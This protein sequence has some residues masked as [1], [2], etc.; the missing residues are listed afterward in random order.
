MV[1]GAPSLLVLLPALRKAGG[2]AALTKVSRDLGRGRPAVPEAGRQVKAGGCVVGRQWRRVEQPARKAESH[3]E[4]PR[5]DVSLLPG[6]GGY[7]YNSFKPRVYSTPPR[8]LAGC[9]RFFLLHH[10]PL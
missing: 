7:T 4:V 10:F 5:H 2:A 1:T 8:S 9:F 3:L 6:L